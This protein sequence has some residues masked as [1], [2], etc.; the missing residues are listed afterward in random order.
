MIGVDWGTSSFRAYRLDRDGRILRPA[1]RAARHH[2]RCPTGGS[3]TTLR[4][5]IGDWLA[6]G[7]RQCCCPA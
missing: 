4:S 1:R 6:A 7:E 3:P 2:D 5:E